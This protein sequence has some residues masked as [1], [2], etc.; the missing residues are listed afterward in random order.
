MVS[1]VPLR[2]PMSPAL[3]QSVLRGDIGHDALQ[4]LLGRLRAD[5]DWTVLD[6]VDQGREHIFVF[7]YQPTG[8]S[9][10]FRAVRIQAHLWR[11]GA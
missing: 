4:M 3:V 1:F 11:F 8:V 5:P 6:A 10:T 9:Y 2:W 7:T